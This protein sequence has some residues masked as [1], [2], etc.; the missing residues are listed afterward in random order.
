MYKF[1]IRF[2]LWLLFI[3]NDDRDTLINI[4][5]QSEGICR[6]VDTKGAKGT[7]PFVGWKRNNII[8]RTLLR[9]GY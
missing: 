9:R 1:L 3:P 7:I 8:I 5:F 6:F 2:L 4:F